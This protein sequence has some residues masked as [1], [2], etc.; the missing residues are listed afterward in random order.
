MDDSGSLRLDKDERGG[1]LSP[2]IW[3]PQRVLCTRADGDACKAVQLWLHLL[4]HARDGEER[5][6]VHSP[7]PKAM[8]SSEER[9]SADTPSSR[10]L[11]REV[12]GRLFRSSPSKGAKQS[13][14]VLEQIL[15]VRHPPHTHTPAELPSELPRV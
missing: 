2:R 9:T 8:T 10:L 12:A 15:V 4:R 5:R 11:H 14:S 3:R 6:S 7:A 13:I 1:V